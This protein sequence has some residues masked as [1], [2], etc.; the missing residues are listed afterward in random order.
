[1]KLNQVVA[2]TVLAGCASAAH[3]VG[4]NVASSGA[5]FGT[6]TPGQALPKDTTGNITVNCTKGT[7]DVLPLTVTYTI[8]LSRGNSS[9]Y[10]PRELKNGGNTLLYNLY[11]GPLRSSVWGSAANGMQV[12]GSLLLTVVSGSGSAIHPAY[13]RIF[14]NQNATPGAYS[15]SIVITINY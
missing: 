1:M 11:T 15:D 14:A 6:Y 10:A 3:G 2:A 7:L 13:G 12:S 4:C 9:S 5:V 8:D